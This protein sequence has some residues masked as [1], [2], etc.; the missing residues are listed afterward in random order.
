MIDEW[1]L[2]E[3]ISAEDFLLKMLD[4][5]SPIETSLIGSF[6]TSGRGS[7]RDIELPLHRDG[8]YTTAFK[9][10]ISYL[11]LF[12]L[13]EGGTAITLLESIDGQIHKIKLRKNQ[14]LIINNKNC[15]HGREG[16]VGD[17]LVLRIWV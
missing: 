13:R 1:I 11:G 9:D 7:R 15:R 3:E 14:A 17:R 2:I 12:C 4:L 16:K 10:K 5:G 6:E 8:D